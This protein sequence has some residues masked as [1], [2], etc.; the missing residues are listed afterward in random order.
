MIERLRA[1]PETR[2]AT[3]T[4][5]QPLADTG[6]IPCVSLLDFWR[7]VGAL[8]LVVYAHSLDCGKKATGNL[9]ELAR[10]QHEVAAAVA[11]PVGSLVIHAK[12]AHVYEPEL[13]TM[14][15]LTQI[16]V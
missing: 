8:E 13:E 12:S 2:S 5:F 14:R 9:V 1:D 11:L 15:R 16:A 3:I 10:L 6:Y 7:S 4:T